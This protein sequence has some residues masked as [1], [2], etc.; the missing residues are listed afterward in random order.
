MK[1]ELRDSEKRTS[2]EAV[3]YM[4]RS[5]GLL[6]FLHFKVRRTPY[7]RC[8]EKWLYVVSEAIEVTRWGIE[9]EME[10]YWEDTGQ[11]K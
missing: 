5:I 4:K 1:G 9:I 11:S 2:C 10:P 3:I 8:K 7:G 6:I